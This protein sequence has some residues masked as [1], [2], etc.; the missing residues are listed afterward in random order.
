MHNIHVE[1]KHTRRSELNN[2]LDFKHKYI[3]T[4]FW[5]LG[6]RSKDRLIRWDQSHRPLVGAHSKPELALYVL[7]HR[8][9][10]QR[11]ERSTLQACIS[12]INFM[13]LKS[14]LT[15]PNPKLNTREWFNFEMGLLWKFP[16]LDHVSSH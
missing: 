5:K 7:A 12:K 9:W 11:V 14:L 8:N 10:H 6:I 4:F 2:K 15:L 1:T 16:F 3:S 13:C